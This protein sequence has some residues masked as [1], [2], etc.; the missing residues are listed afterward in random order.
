MAQARTE[1]EWVERIRQ[2]IASHPV[3][4]YAKGEKHA[5]VCGF[6]HRV[7]ELFDRLGVDYEVRDV[8]ADPLIRPA[9]RAFTS[10]P[11]T[12]QVFIGGRFV[13]GCDTVTELAENGELQKLLA[14]SRQ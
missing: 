12:P 13:G 14:H 11:T 6:S 9:L 5:A 3:L 1:Q 10:C 4:I 7:M 8:F 2:D